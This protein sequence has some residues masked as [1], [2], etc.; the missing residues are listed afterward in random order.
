MSTYT[1]IYSPV[2]SNV[3]HTSIDVLIDTDAYGTIP[4][5]ASP[6]DCTDYGPVIFKQAAAGVFGEVAEYAAPGTPEKTEAEIIEQNT[7]TYNALLRAC[8]DAAFPLQSAITL[9]VATDE[10]RAELAVLQQYAVDLMSVDLTANPVV[11]P[12][13]PASLT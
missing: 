12:D 9:G 13:L 4:F 1:R 6:T 3:D 10:Q 11:F 7:A 8:T 2:W 5:T